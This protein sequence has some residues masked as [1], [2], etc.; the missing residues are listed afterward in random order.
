[1]DWIIN[2]LE[3]KSN[4]ILI[5]LL[6]ALLLIL[7]GTR[8]SPSAQEIS[9]S[10]TPKGI[11]IPVVYFDDPVEEPP[12]PDPED[13]DWLQ[14]LNYYREMAGLPPLSLDTDWNYGGWLH[15][16]YMVKNDVIGHSEDPEKPWYT[17]EGDQA[18][19]TSNLVAS[20]SSTLSDQYAIDLWMQAPFHGVGILDPTLHTIGY[21]SF[22]EKDGGLQTG[23]ALDVLRGLGE[24][25]TSVSYPVAWPKDGSTVALTNH[26]SEYPDPLSSCPGYDPPAGLPILLQIGPG[27][28]TPNVTAHSFKQGN[29][30]LEHCV[31]DETSYENPVA[32]SQSL[33]RAILGSRDAIVLIPKNPLLPGKMY[34]VSLTVNG[35]TTTWSFSVS[36]QAS[37]KTS[38][39]QEDFELENFLIR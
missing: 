31:F 34:S 1:M 32:G 37:Q 39:M 17:Q 11:Y 23:A 20:H 16:R 13:F 24:L 28:L 4:R 7:I 14:Y 25:P 18:A 6:I 30:S 2:L 33:G 12:G 15:S 35:K 10:Q 19:R 5:S 22:R 3:N 26:F 29:E 36:N 8:S 9:G 38:R 27:N 21:G